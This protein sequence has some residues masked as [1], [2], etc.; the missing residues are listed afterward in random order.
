M[1][2]TFEKI[3]STFYI[4][5][6]IILTAL[7][8]IF[9]DNGQ[10][11]IGLVN[12]LKLESNETIENFNLLFILL[13]LFLATFFILVI[14]ITKNQKGKNNVLENHVA[15]QKLASPYALSL[16]EASLDPL[17]TISTEGKIMDTNE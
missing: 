14:L 13:V 1:K 17:V 9:Y 8:A 11:V 12:P 15:D 6:S 16:I 10:K 7:L 4:L 2:F 3:T 5:S